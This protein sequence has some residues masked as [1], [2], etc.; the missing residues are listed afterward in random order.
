MYWNGYGSSER[1]KTRDRNPAR[2]VV[3][4]A[5][6]ARAPEDRRR[7]ATNGYSGYE[8]L[9]A[10]GGATTPASERIAASPCRRQK[11]RVFLFP[12]SVAV[13]LASPPSRWKTPDQWQ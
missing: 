8:V 5:L 12:R 11:T 2:E 1:S 9:T 7:H 13:R 4:V 6:Y 3:P 10:C